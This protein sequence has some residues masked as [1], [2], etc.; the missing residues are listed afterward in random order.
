MRGRRVGAGGD[1]F[2]ATRCAAGHT[3]QITWL[4][5]AAGRGRE[6]EVDEAGSRADQFGLIFRGFRTASQNHTRVR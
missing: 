5:A 4:V 1:C 2:E 3:I 6:A